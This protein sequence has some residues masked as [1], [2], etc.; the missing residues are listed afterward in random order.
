MNQIV[1]IG[2]G[3]FGRETANVIERINAA[4]AEP[5]WELLGFADDDP[6]VQGT[7]IDGYPVIGTIASLNQ[8]AQ[9]C[10]AVCSLG[11]AATRKKVLDKITNPHIRFATLIDPEAHLYKGVS[12][13]EGSIICGG[14]V[15]AINV[16]VGNH[17]VIN[18][19]CT[20]GHDA[21]IGACSV[22]N[23][24]VNISGKVTVG[25]C[26]NLGTGSKIIQGLKIGE[27][28]T[29]GAGAVVIRDLP[30]NCTAVGSPAKPIKYHAS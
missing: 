14:T 16:S 11:V 23:P 19:N 17:V 27:N 10:F 21:V 9:E 20:L 13:G 8:A 15:L 6:S 1:I 26:S 30:E 25:C 29:V 12:V 24:G 28:T 22:I 18:L 5:V 3:D 2:A 7:K 4:A